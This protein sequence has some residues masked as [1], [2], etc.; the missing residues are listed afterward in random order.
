[1]DKRIIKIDKSTISNRIGDKSIDR[2]FSELTPKPDVVSLDQFFD[3]YN[4]LFYDIPRNGTL[5][6]KTLIDQSTDYYGAYINPNQSEVD[7]L[8]AQIDV[9][10]QQLL[11]IETSQLNIPT[12]PIKTIK[13]AVRLKYSHRRRYGSADDR[14]KLSFNLSFTDASGVVSTKSYNFIN[15]RDNDLIVEFTSTPGTIRYNLEGKLKDKKYKSG[16]QS[17]TIREDSPDTIDLTIR[18]NE[19]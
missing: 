8:K 10:N 2:S 4:Q 7:N 17:F 13:L 14:N 18:A 15:L 3:Y 11:N 16:Q 6:H 19:Q 9:L 12:P 5:S 1:M